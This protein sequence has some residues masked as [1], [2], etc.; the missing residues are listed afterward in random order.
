MLYEIVLNENKLNEYQLGRISG[1]I[2]A[3]SGMPEQ[4]YAIKMHQDGDRCSMFFKGNADI[5]YEV[6]KAIN[7]LYPGVMVEDI[8]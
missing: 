1:I 4:G 3:L 2:Y 7:K 5:L 8:D 6:Q